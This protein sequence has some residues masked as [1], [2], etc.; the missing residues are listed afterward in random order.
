M[1]S[2]DLSEAVTPVFLSLAV[3]MFCSSNQLAPDLMYRKP[4]DRSVKT[5]IELAISLQNKISAGGTGATLS[6]A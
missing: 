4:A 6:L 1:D 3:S 5:S 2:V